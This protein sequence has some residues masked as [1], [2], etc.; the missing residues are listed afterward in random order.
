MNEKLIGIIVECTK[1]KEEDIYPDAELTDDLG[2]SSLDIAN[3][4]I[5]I[6]EQLGCAAT[7]REIDK[8]KTVGDIEAYLA[9]HLK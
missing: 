6:E 1:L 5:E 8:I 4:F 7:D 9:K 2:L 3:I